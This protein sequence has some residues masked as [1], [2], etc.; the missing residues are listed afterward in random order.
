MLW[1]ILKKTYELREPKEIEKCEA[2]GQVP[3]M[4]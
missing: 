4:S 3:Q 1:S 2:L